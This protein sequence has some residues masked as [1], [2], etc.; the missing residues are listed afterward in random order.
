[1]TTHTADCQCEAECGCCGHQG[2]LHDGG[3]CVASG[4]DY[5]G[6]VC[7]CIPFLPPEKAR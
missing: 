2:W 1:M 5:D 6:P 3:K 7:G 4:P